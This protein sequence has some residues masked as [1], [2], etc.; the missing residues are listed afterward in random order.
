MEA[1]HFILTL[2][3]SNNNT[4]KDEDINILQIA[5]MSIT[6]PELIN[7]LVEH[8]LLRINNRICTYKFADGHICG[9]TKILKPHTQWKNDGHAV[10]CELHGKVERIRTE[11]WFAIGKKPLSQMLYI[12]YIL[13]C[14]ASVKVCTK[15]FRAVRLHRDTVSTYLH[16]LQRRMLLK[17]LNNHTPLFNPH[18]EVEIDEMWVD[19]K[20]YDIPVGP[21]DKKQMLQKG[22]WVV[23]VINRSQTKLWME[24]VRDRRQYTLKKLISPL[25]KKWVWNRGKVY[26]DALKS[27]GFLKEGVS[28]HVINKKQDGFARCSHTFWGNC[29]NVH[30]NNIESAWK[31]LRKHLRNRNA[32]VA[33][34]YVHLHIA[35]FVYNWYQLSWYNVIQFP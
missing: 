9:K 16:D 25:L 29:N 5:P 23:G 3:S 8:R 1:I 32:Y 18:D 13:S 15:F 10:A 7:L 11:S 6:T 12:L 34:Q 33:P 20:E 2:L 17:L 14:G 31:D 35:E 28:H 4:I 24:V 26:T 21:G 27:Y 19:W 30:V 22:V